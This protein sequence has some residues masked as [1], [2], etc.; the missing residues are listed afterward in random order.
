MFTSLDTNTYFFPN[1]SRTTQEGAQGLWDY[2]EPTLDA[3]RDQKKHQKPLNSIKNLKS[4]KIDPDSFP[5]AD[6]EIYYM[7]NIFRVD[8]AMSRCISK[9]KSMS[10]MQVAIFRFRPTNHY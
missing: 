4:F 8:L 3:P 5:E 9:P 2:P 7:S 6:F 10:Q 1:R